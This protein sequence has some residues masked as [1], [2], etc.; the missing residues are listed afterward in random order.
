VIK[1]YVRLGLGMGIVAEM[2]VRDDGS[3]S[4]L[5]GAPAGPP[6]WPER[7]PRGLQAQRLPAQ[8]CLQICRVAQRPADRNLIAKAMTGHVNDY[9]L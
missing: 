4:D 7:G 6:V 8:L 5:A 1:T 2:A 3:N 9:E